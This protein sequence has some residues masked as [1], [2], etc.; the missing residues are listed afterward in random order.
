MLGA[1]GSIM[2]FDCLIFSMRRLKN[3]PDL[4]YMLNI[5]RRPFSYFALKIGKNFMRYIRYYSLSLS[6]QNMCDYQ[7][8]YDS[9]CNYSN[10][11]STNSTN[12]IF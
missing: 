4:D 10:S 8:D 7:H 1:P 3:F 9:A 11:N 12:R 6:Q 2:Y 5:L